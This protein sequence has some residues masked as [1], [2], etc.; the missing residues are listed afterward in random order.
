MNSVLSGKTGGKKKEW[1]CVVSA[2]VISS[3]EGFA[4]MAKPLE[5]Y[6]ITNIHFC[7]VKERTDLDATAIAFVPF[8]DFIIVGRDASGSPY[9]NT[10][11]REAKELQIPVLSESCITVQGKK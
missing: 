5:D 7:S 2:M 4:G 11:L 1:R 6:G 8:V 9:L 3:A 10:I